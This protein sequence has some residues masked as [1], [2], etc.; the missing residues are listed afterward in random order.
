VVEAGGGE[1]IGPEVVAATEQQDGAGD[2][3]ETTDVIALHFGLIY[4]SVEVT[5]S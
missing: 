2:R 5:R 3:R 1:P 4:P